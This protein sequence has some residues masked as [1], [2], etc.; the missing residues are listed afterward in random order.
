[1]CRDREI[2]RSLPERDTEL[3][4]LREFIGTARSTPSRRSEYRIAIGPKFSQKSAPTDPSRAPAQIPPDLPGT[5][6]RGSVL[7]GC[8][9]RRRYS[10]STN[11]E[12]VQ[13]HA[14]AFFCQLVVEANQENE[15][16][17]SLSKAD[18]EFPETESPLVGSCCH[19]L[20]ASCRRLLRNGKRVALSDVTTRM[21]REGTYG[22]V[23]APGSDPRGHSARNPVKMSLLLFPQ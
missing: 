8:G 6:P 9:A 3:R 16:P 7:R 5:K 13:I 19:R 4:G 1:M 18:I 12:I 20:L 10:V 15:C 21:P 22:S 14:F 11:N 23:G 2:N 17:E